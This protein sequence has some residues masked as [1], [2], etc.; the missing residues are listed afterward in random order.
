[1]NAVLMQDSPAHALPRSL[2]RVRRGSVDAIEDARHLDAMTAEPRTVDALTTDG[3]C[4]EF[5]WTK[6]KSLAESGKPV[7]SSEEDGRCWEKE[8][9]IDVGSWGK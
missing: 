2:S 5:C 7:T 3:D 9:K 8:R 6:I 4:F 1:M